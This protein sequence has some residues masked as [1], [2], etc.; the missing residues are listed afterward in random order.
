MTT[1]WP[2]GLVGARGSSLT[3]TSCSSSYLADIL[4]RVIY[5][6]KKS[7]FYIL[8]RKSYI[9]VYHIQQIAPNKGIHNL[10]EL[11]SGEYR[12]SI[13]RKGDK[14]WMGLEAEFV[15]TVYTV[16][17]YIMPFLNAQ[18]HNTSLYH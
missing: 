11:K 18:G 10:L 14:I 3:P 1:H 6:I 12:D 4:F 13:K 7:H 17:V 16:H 2:H 5:V 15:G 9:H 8:Q